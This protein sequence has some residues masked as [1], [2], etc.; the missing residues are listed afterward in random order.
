VSGA[1]HGVLI[2]SR[3][4]AAAGHYSVLALLCSGSVA[5]RVMS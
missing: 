3:R 5:H 1:R 4:Y 2:S